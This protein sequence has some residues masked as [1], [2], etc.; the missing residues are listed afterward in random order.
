TYTR[1][2]G[3]ILCLDIMPIANDTGY[4]IPGALVTLV[5]SDSNGEILG[6]DEFN[7]AAGV[8][9]AN[10]TVPEVGLYVLRITIEKEHHETWIRDIV[11]SS[12]EDPGVVFIQVFSAGLLGALA[13][14]MAMI[15]GVAGRRYYTK[16]SARRT[17]ELLTW[18][19]RLEDAKNLIGLL[20]IHRSVGL[21][22]YSRVIKGGFQESML[23][24]FIAA[25]AQ[26]RSEFSWEEPIWTAIPISE[27]VTAVQT[28]VLICAIIT[29]EQASERQKTQLE[30]FGRDVGGLYDHEED[31]IRE[32]FHTPELSDVFS[33]T[34]DPIFESYFD[35]ALFSRY[36][37]VRKDLPE[38]LTPVAEAFHSLSID[39]GVTP[40]AMIKAVILQG[41]S[42]SRAYEM[43][44]EAI[45]ARYLIVGEKKLPSP[46]E[47]S[48]SS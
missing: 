36:V 1:T 16:Q 37:G 10:I 47:P 22:V 13:L 2:A 28:E 38:H 44:L 24:S 45:D 42:E 40:E 11:L 14:G 5:L 32:M 34:F 35:G 8:Y 4:M 7:Y 17:L 26:F 21:P 43:V 27:V 41:Q 12:E 30:T 20:V 19:G 3:T 15:V 46:V 23:S 6:E 29:V 39:H 31:T 9:S 18:K 48:E 33:R 25:I